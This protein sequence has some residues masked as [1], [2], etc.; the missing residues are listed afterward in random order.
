MILEEIGRRTL[1]LIK[2]ELKIIDYSFAIPYT[3]VMIEGKD[4]KS[5]GVAV[6][7]MEEIHSFENN[8]PNVSLGSFLQMAESFNI[9]E[10][11]LCLATIN[12]VSQYYIDLRDEIDDDL[13]QF[14]EKETDIEKVAVIGSMFPTVQKLQEAGKKVFVF[15][16]NKILFDK[17]TIS[18]GLE[19]QLLPTMDAILATGA[20]LLN[21]TIDLILDRTNNAKVVALLGPTAQALPE[22]FKGRHVTHLCSSKVE[23]I[24]DALTNLKLGSFK[25]SGKYNKRYALKVES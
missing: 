13:V 11:T 22:L 8:A 18:D 5:I 19:Y 7:L 21:G 14:L 20:V 24:D 2:E 6:T 12:A 17:N 3:Y 25:G 10:R 1:R 16:R 9:I 4:K 23:D 15:E